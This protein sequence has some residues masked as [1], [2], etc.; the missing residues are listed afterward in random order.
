AEDVDG[1]RQ[2]KTVSERDA[3]QPR[4]PADRR[5]VAENGADARKT[6]VERAQELGQAWSEC[7]HER[8]CL[9]KLRNETQPRKP[10]TTK[11]TSRRRF[12]HRYTETGRRHRLKPPTIRNAAWL[13]RTQR[14]GGRPEAAATPGAD[15]YAGRT[16]HQ[17]DRVL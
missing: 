15:R 4:R 11:K 5:G 1:D 9:A 12:R 14:F 7:L 8:Q 2:R 6:E 10:E 3:E 17:T 16:G 13:K